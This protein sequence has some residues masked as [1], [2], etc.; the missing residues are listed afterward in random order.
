MFW[1]KARPAMIT[2]AQ[3]EFV[4]ARAWLSVV[5]QPSVIGFDQVVSVSLGTGAGGRAQLQ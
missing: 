4:W 1:M 5:I 2:R 3:A